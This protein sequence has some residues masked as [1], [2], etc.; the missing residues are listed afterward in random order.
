[1]K[2]KQYDLKIEELIRHRDELKMISKTF[3]SDSYKVRN[4]LM[5]KTKNPN[6]EFLN[7]L[8]TLE[9]MLIDDYERVLEK[10]YRIKEK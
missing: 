8:K 10:E 5:D 9:K 7:A 1:M 6:V 3:S 2:K 4:D